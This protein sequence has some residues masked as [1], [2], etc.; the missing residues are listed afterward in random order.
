M[1]YFLWTFA[2]SDWMDDSGKML[3]G[4]STLRMLEAVPTT[5]MTIQIV[6]RLSQPLW[7]FMGHSG[8]QGTVGNWMLEQRISPSRQCI[9]RR[10]H[11][12]FS[13][14]MASLGLHEL[15]W[16]PAANICL[17]VVSCF[18]V[19]LAQQTADSGHCVPPG[20][21]MVFVVLL[22]VLSQQW[23]VFISWRPEKKERGEVPSFI[24]MLV[25]ACVRDSVC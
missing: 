19:I 21:S 10:S 11:G 12:S 6:A 3:C 14:T 24:T 17:L 22:Q 13:R 1:N 25:W 8:W 23:C 15:D 9:F 20:I 5:K 18:L 16:L 2:Q 7:W 4:P